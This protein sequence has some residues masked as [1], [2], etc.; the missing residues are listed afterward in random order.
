MDEEKKGVNTGEG[1]P[2][3]V[4]P[5]QE[6]TEKTPTDS[7]AV[8]KEKPIESSDSKIPYSR[9]QEVNER[10]KAAEAKV[11][12]FEQAEA[13]KQFEEWIK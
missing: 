11:S 8:A 3:A 7:G 10:M 1:T 4:T 5:P 12:Q 13:K 6:I 2:Q 9:F